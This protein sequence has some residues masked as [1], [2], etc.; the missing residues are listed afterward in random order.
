M[1]NQHTNQPM[2]F[3]QIAIT[4]CI[5]LFAILDS[6]AAPVYLRSNV[7][8]PW[9]L[10]GNE[11][12]MDAVFGTGNWLDQRFEIANPATVFSASNSFVFLEG[13]D[14]SADELETYLN[15]NSSLIST[16]VTAGGKLLINAAPNEG[17]GMSLGFDVILNYASGSGSNTGSSS[18]NPSHPIFLGPETPVGSNFTGSSF[19]H[20][21]ITGT[22][23]TTILLDS[24]NRIIL[25]EKSIGLG[26]VVFGGLTLPFFQTH[27]SW[28][29]QPNVANLHQNII[30]YAASVPEP[31][32]GLLL[33]TGMGVT[34]LLRR[35]RSF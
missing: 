12:A 26:N 27:P 9:G 5:L 31:A 1:K 32:T 33:M 18:S 15:T 6:P 3:V 10:L 24:S 22:G 17:N 30:S 25:G 19:S 29:P 34:A 2:H 16:W 13:G 7:G 4:V 28:T 35:R 23:L 21:Y 20:A 11:T 8:A 14:S